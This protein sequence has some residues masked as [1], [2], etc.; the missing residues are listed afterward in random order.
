VKFKLEKIVSINKKH[1]RGKVYDI[2][3]ENKQSY[4]IK[5]IAVHN[6]LCETRIRT[7]VGIPQISTLVDV[8]PVGDIYDVPVIADGGIRM[9]GDIAKCL[10]VGADSV[11][12]GSLLSGTKE[13]PG[14]IS[15]VGQWPNEQL[16]KKYRGSA[17]LDSKMGRE[18]SKNVEGA[19]KLTA[20]KGKTKRII[21][22]ITDGV[23][24]A[25]SYVGANNIEEFQ[26]R[27]E[28]VE[29]TESGKMEAYP[30]GINI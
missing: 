23:R 28:F 8:I 9:V 14:E 10:G 26:S 27:C 17:S 5:G 6:S 3:V 29:V 22:D 21:N 2:T 24:S 30:H 18:E 12:L 16:Y 19:S 13:T 15:K 4:N 20:Y 1:Y 11:M 25:F 7:G